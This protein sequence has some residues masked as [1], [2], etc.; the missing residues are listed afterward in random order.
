MHSAKAEDGLRSGQAAFSNHSRWPENQ[1]RNDQVTRR[2]SY[3]VDKTVEYLCAIL[4]TGEPYCSGRELWE[5][6]PLE[7]MGD[8]CLAEDEKL[9]PF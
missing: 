5:K 3:R 7:A 8:T 4:E 1:G 2:V 9:W 6:G